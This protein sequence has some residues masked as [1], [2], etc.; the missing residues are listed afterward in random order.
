MTDGLPPG[1]LT[2]T[3]T[4]AHILLKS[5]EQHLLSSSTQDHRITQVDSWSGEFM[6]RV[7]QAVGTAERNVDVVVAS[8][9]QHG[10][11]IT[12]LCLRRVVEILGCS[13]TMRVLCPRT[14]LTPAIVND[15][16][17]K[18]SAIEWRF[19]T[20]LPIE[21]VM[22]DDHVAVLRP[23]LP[24][25]IQACVVEEPSV[26]ALLGTLFDNVWS[27]AQPAD[28]SFELAG[29]SEPE[30]FK[31]IITLLLAGHTDESAARKL[32]LSVRT[33]RRHVARILRFLGAT[34]RFEA[35]VRAA[36]R[37]LLPRE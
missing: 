35:G 6:E 25:Q 16:K 23:C 11:A 13:V 10:S 31:Q 18:T 28:G 24:S 14:A 32:S 3:L 19:A 7:A 22:V 9:T 36:E 29:D 17:A 20:S 5:A 21:A 15:F 12:Q 1:E 34:S 2:R 33:Y 30:L 26:L 27:T 8:L 4:H 37:G